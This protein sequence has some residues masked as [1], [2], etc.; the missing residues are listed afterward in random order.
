MKRDKHMKKVADI[1]EI[2]VA[3]LIL[4]VVLH[5]HAF[6]AFLVVFFVLAHVFILL[7][8]VVRLQAALSLEL[9]L[10]LGR[11]ALGT[12]TRPGLSHLVEQ[13][14]SLSLTLA[15]RLWVVIVI[16]D[17]LVVCPLLVVD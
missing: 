3:T 7:V 2:V 16:E 8:I 4:L 17:L 1:S 12:E 9:L 10:A 11:T 14:V 15:A 5:I 13:V 6:T